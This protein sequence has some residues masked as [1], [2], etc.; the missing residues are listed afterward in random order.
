MRVAVLGTGRMGESMARRLRQQGFELTLWNRTPQ[1][2][3][4]LELAPVATTPV[5]AVRSADVVISALADDAAVRDV[6][7]RPEGALQG[8][9]GRVFVEASTVSPQLMEE[10]AHRVRERG[11][12]FLDA[13]VLGSVPAVLEGRLGVLVGGERADLER[14]MPVL[15]ALGEVRPV[16]AAGSA[17][18][19]KLVSNSMLAGV[20]ALAAELEAA[21]VAVGLDR[22]DVFWALAR[23]VPYLGVRR[24]GYVEDVHEPVTFPVR[25]LL[26]DLDLALDLFRT[27]SA[28]TPYTSLGRQIFAETAERYADLD[29]SAVARYY[30][31]PSAD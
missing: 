17:A 13:P 27:H 6:Y 28:P 24:R 14:A 16:G 2:A 1:R 25:G 8:A 4:A 31:S 19:L 18:R 12:R 5:A 30:A 10:L 15:R 22:E 20:S 29:L 26:K 9:E 3:R 21:G 7:T 23:L 11:G